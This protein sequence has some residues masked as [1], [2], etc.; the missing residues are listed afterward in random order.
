LHLQRRWHVDLA[1]EIV[2]G[3]SDTHECHLQYKEDEVLRKVA[4]NRV[5]SVFLRDDSAW[6]AYIWIVTISLGFSAS[7]VLPFTSSDG[8]TSAERIVAVCISFGIAV[9]S[10]VLCT[11]FVLSGVESWV[12]ML[13]VL[14]FLAFVSYIVLNL[15]KEVSPFD[16]ALAGGLYGTIIV[17]AAYPLSV[18]G[19]VTGSRWERR[20]WPSDA[21]VATIVTGLYE[22]AQGL[23]SIERYPDHDQSMERRRDLVNQIDRIAWFLEKEL[24]NR[25]AESDEWVAQE[26]ASRAETV[27]NWKKPIWLPV[28]DSDTRRLRGEIIHVLAHAL[29]GE[30]GVITK[31]ADPR[32]QASWYRRLLRAGFF[33][34]TLIPLVFLLVAPA[35]GI[36]IE[37]DLR[38]RL[39]A[40]AIPLALVPLA[41]VGPSHLRDAIMDLATNRHN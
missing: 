1:V 28:D 8:G 23:G 6:P 32:E 20:K 36:V 17:L 21:V 33:A 14:A 5:R 16:R 7:V 11:G 3:E 35:M 24:P 31:P 19:Q 12:G 39:L 41:W 30:W 2:V 9:L 13:F 29:K 38:D 18:I 37:P 34:I 10:A 26:L 40:L 27:R 25:I 4:A 22:I 15:N